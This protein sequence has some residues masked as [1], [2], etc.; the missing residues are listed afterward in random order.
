MRKRMNQLFKGVMIFG[1]MAVMMLGCYPKGP[2]YYSDLDIT[3]T[4]HDENYDFGNVKYYW[5]PDTVNIEGNIDLSA[6]E[7]KELE[8]LILG[9]LETQFSQRGYVRLFEDDPILVDSLDFIVTSDVIGVNYN[10][11]VWVPGPGWGWWGPGWGYWYPWYP[12]YPGGY[13]PYY[14]SYSTGSVITTIGDIKNIDDNDKNIP[15]VWQSVY[16]G[17]MSSSQSSNRD[18]ARASIQQSFKQ[19]PYLQSNR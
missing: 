5:M 19:S 9:E 3:A 18:R 14:Y 1:G 11:G 6:S 4:H 17:L 7:R 2:E 10:G 15:A 16:D 13:Y 12:G 8:N